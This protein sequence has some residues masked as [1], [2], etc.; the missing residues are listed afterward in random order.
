M[1]RRPA[2]LLAVAALAA[3]AYAWTARGGDGAP[4]GGPPGAAGVSRA[5]R[6]RHGRRHDPRRAGQPLRARAVH[7]D[8]HARGGASGHAGAVL[9]AARGGRERPAR[10]RPPGAAGARRRG[11]RPLR[12][13]ARLRLPGRRRPVRERGARARRVRPHADDQA[14]RAL[15]RA[16]RRARARGPPRR[17]GALGRCA[18]SS[19]HPPWRCACGRAFPSSSGPSSRRS[20]RTAPPR[21]PTAP[22][23]SARASATRA[24]AQ[25]RLDAIRAPRARALATAALVTVAMFAR[26]TS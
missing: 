25:A 10:R 19:L 13:P 26:C 16:V 17:T 14:E 11:A 7:R 24:P 12:A 23:G 20:R 18:R 3:L 22:R 2:V 8:R 21:A 5:C 4:V 15:R 1:P 6:A 9:R